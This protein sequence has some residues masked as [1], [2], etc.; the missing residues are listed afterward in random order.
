MLIFQGLNIFIIPQANK[1]FVVGLPAF[2][3]YATI[4]IVLNKYYEN[5]NLKCLNL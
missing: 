2:C 5:N 3:L 4:M 1:L